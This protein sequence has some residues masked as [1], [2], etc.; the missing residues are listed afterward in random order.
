MMYSKVSE[1]I[2]TLKR[3]EERACIVGFD[4][5][6][7]KLHTRLIR[8]LKMECDANNIDCREQVKML[9]LANIDYTSLQINC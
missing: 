2:D 5:D 7:A 1:I 4:L 3:V 8:E 9:P 6:D